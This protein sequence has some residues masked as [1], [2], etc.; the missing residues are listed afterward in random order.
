MSNL[1]R[2]M[3]YAAAFEET[4]ADNNWQRLEQ[5]FTPDAS[6]APGDGTIAQGREK[7]LSTLSNAVT[8]LDH[9]FDSRSFGDNPAPSESE[10]VVTMKWTLI[11]EKQNLPN[12][13]ISGTEYATFSGNAIQKL[14]DV[15]DEG[16]IQ[17][18][19]EWMQAHGESLG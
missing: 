8:S 9:K 18:L 11:L 16:A 13:T 17:G 7:I 12:L 1:E 2:F 10:N 19:T 14:E 3:E 4:Y 5:Y 6:Y 15:Y